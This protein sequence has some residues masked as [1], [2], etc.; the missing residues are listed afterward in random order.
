MKRGILIFWSALL[1]GCGG[2]SK[3]PVFNPPPPAAPPPSN[4]AISL[5]SGDVSFASRRHNFSPDAQTV[6]AS[7]NSSDT[8]LELVFPSGS[9]R[10]DWL[11]VERSGTSSPVNIEFR[12]ASTD[13][14]PDNYTAQM[15]VVARAGDGTEQDR[16]TINIAFDVDVSSESLRAH[17]DKIMHF[18]QEVILNGASVPWSAPNGW[19]NRDIGTAINGNPDTNTAAFQT[20]FGRIANAGGNSTRIWLH[21][22]T[23]VTPAIENNGNVTGLSRELTNAQVAGQL[24]EIL[25]AAW[26]EG[27]L[28]TFSLFSFDMI[29]DMFDPLPGKRMMENHYQSYIDNALIPMVEGT[30]DHPALLAWE[31]F[32]EPEGMSFTNYFCASSETISTE[33]VQNVVNRTAAAIHNVDPNVKVTT[34]THTELYDRFSN[35]TL[36]SIPDADPGGV[37]DFYELH[38]YDTGWQSPP[39]SIGNDAYNADRPIIIGEFDVEGTGAGGPAGEDTSRIILE[40][41]FYGTWAWSMVTGNVP[42]IESAITEAAPL[43]TPIDKAAIETCIAN[44][45]ESCYIQ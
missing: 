3:A 27:I 16:E 25:D 10:P 12:I 18:G 8:S 29:C 43:A 28:V 20:H 31:V 15:D 1:V 24:N 11:E 42:L 37:L 2:G 40:N 17:E 21:T 22:A 14:A 23:T 45:P 9:P 38:W 26:D 4:V 36:K 33:V 39:Y 6:S 34:S 5:S 41:G 7:W 19:Y 35:A 30:K 13:L 32:N 44:K